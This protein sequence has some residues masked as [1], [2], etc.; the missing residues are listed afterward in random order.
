MFRLL[1][2]GE[3]NA[4]ID[5]ASICVGGGKYVAPTTPPNKAA[6]LLRFSKPRAR[7]A[8]V[9]EQGAGAP[10][11]PNLH[12]QRQPPP[13]PRSSRDNG[14]GTTSRLK[15]RNFGMGRKQGTKRKT[16]ENFR[17]SQASLPF[18]WAREVSP[19]RSRE[20]KGPL[21]L[22]KSE[23]SAGWGPRLRA[24]EGG[25]VA[26]ASGSG[27][28][29]AA[30]LRSPAPRPASPELAPRALPGRLAPGPPP[31]SRGRGRGR[32]AAGFQA[33]RAHP[34]VRARGSRPPPRQA[35]GGGAAGPAARRGGARRAALRAGL[36]AVPTPTP[37]A[38]HCGGA[39]GGGH[40][41]RRRDSASARAGPPPPPPPPPPGRCRARSPACAVPRA[42]GPFA[43]PGP[44]PRPAPLASRRQRPPAHPGTGCCPRARRER[45]SSGPP[46]RA[47]G[48]P[49]PR[50]RGRLADG[51]GPFRT[52]GPRLPAARH[53]HRHSPWAPRAHCTQA[54]DGLDAGR[55][56]TVGG[57][58]F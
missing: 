3:L 53:S 9:T 2:S 52:P 26:A 36:W 56:G 34:G 41:L 10:A 11:K 20:V 42:P 6:P 55:G 13:L 1:S 30:G 22:S 25:P 5:V 51:P 19:P 47:G 58:V 14:D 18:L 29:R 37:T 17:A 43:R 15:A 24:Q 49:P 44:G 23:S 7:W 12:K 38:V 21:F 33:P 50:P 35:A 54:G 46:R 32:R 16:R 28:G 8:A 57:S 45:A 27:S 48:R 39:S 4:K 40:E 31:P